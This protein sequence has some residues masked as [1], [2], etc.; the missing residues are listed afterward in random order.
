[1]A[2][3]KTLHGAENTKRLKK[4]A[5]LNEYIKKLKGAPSVV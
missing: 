2:E 1:M 4:R 5:L 3:L